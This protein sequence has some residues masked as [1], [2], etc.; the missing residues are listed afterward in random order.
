MWDMNFFIQ[1]MEYW[2]SCLMRIF[3][4]NICEYFI[5]ALNVDKPLLISP[6]IY[7]FNSKILILVP[8]LYY[9]PTYTQSVTDPGF[10]GRG[11]CMGGGGLLTHHEG[12][13]HCPPPPSNRGRK[14]DICI[15]KVIKKW[16]LDLYFIFWKAE[17]YRLHQ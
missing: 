17:E 13:V 1:S 10:G 12:V 4:S 14:L 15:F 2:D 6:S 5:E 11:L 16:V 3:V 8:I 7:Y 9:S